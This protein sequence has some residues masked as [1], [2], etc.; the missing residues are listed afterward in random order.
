[1][2]RKITK[3]LLLNQIN[4]TKS[5]GLC[6]KPPVGAFMDGIIFQIVNKLTVKSYNTVAYAALQLTIAQFALLLIPKG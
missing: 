1:M 3:F 6:T 5:N 4:S 2:R